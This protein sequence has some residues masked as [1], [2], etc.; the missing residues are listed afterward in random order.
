MPVRWTHHIIRAT[1][2]LGKAKDHAER[3]RVKGLSEAMNYEFRR[4]WKEYYR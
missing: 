2:L 3:P 4:V 1:I